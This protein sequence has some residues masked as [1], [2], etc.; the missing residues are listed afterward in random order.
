MSSICI[1]VDEN[2]VCRMSAG[3]ILY[4]ETTKELFHSWHKKVGGN[5]FIYITKT[6]GYLSLNLDFG[7]NENARYKIYLIFEMVLQVQ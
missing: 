2:C 7:C 6:K 3:V 5:T 4:G 1:L